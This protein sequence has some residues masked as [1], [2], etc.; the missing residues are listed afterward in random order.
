MKKLI[1]LSEME[2]ARALKLCM[3]MQISVGTKGSASL[4][5]QGAQTIAPCKTVHFD[6]RQDRSVDLIKINFWWT[7]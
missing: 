2:Y 4:N 6:Y 1:T 3:F 5:N 7:S